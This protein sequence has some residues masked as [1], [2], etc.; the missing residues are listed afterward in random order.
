MIFR[1]KRTAEVFGVSNEILPDSY[2]DR[3]SLDA[4]IQRLLARPTHIALRGESKCGKSWLRQ[5][6]V[7]DAITVQCRLKKTVKDIYVD[8]LSQLEIKLTIEASGSASVTGTAQAT[9]E[10]G[11]KLLA[12]IGGQATVQTQSVNTEKSSPAG[13]NVEDLRFVAD[14]IKTSGR[15]ASLLR[16]SII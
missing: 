7:P 14:V 10:I 6:N 9:G 16:I 12:K 2:V 4:R 13:H 8:T 1:K 5:K 3:G 15:R 11:I